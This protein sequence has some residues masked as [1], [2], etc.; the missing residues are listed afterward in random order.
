MEFKINISSEEFTENVTNLSAD[1]NETIT[2]FIN[3]LIES[4]IDVENIPIILMNALVNVSTRRMMEASRNIANYTGI[5]SLKTNATPLFAH[6]VDKIIKTFAEN[7]IKINVSH[8]I[9]KEDEN[10]DD[11]DHL[12][13]PEGITMH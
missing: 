4:G 8:N 7:N 3:Q 2:I 12:K 10:C 5:A 13:M 11:C 6:F 1:I 9:D